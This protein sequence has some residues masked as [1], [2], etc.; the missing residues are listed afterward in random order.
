MRN[1]LWIVIVGAALSGPLTAQ[2]KPPAAAPAPAGQAF[3]A[4]V[5]SVSGS[6]QK[7]LTTAKEPKWEPLKAGDQLDEMTVIRTGLRSKVV[8][9]LADRGEFTLDS[10]TKMGIAELRKS[11]QQ[12]S[13]AV[14][15]KYGMVRASVESARGPNDVRIAT[16][17]ATLAVRHSKANVAFAEFGMGLHVQ[18]SPWRATNN[19]SLVRTFYP[20]QVTNDN[21]TPWNTLAP[22]LRAIYFGDHRGLTPSERQFLANFGEGRGQFRFLRELN[23]RE[24]DTLQSLYYI[25]DLPPCCSW[26]RGIIRRR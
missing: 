26:I 19:V 25:N 7:L 5:A 15:L 1:M 24:F 9:K 23:R 2:D 17:T 11:G 20:G 22:L 3:K 8:L 21:L 16:P 4:T 18:Q 13:A 12:V 10:A 14:G 6:A